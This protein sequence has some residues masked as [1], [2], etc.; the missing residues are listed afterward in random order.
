MLARI[1]LLLVVIVD[2]MGQGLIFP[3]INTLLIDP[4]A[5]FLPKGTLSSTREFYYGLVS[6][7]FYLFWFFGAAYI[8]KLSD[9]IGRKTGIV[10]CLVGAVAGYGLTILAIEFSSLWMLIL[11][12]A[13]SGFT[14]GN[15]PIAQAALIDASETEQEKSS[16][17]GYIVGASAIGMMIGPL[18]AGVL[19]DN[20]ILGSYA[21]LELPFYVAIVLVVLTLALIL[22][23]YSDVRL[24]RKPIDFGLSEVF[25]TLYRIREFP[26]VQKL[27][28]GYFFFLMGLNAYYIYLADYLIERFKFTTF[29][30]SMM[31]VILGLALML[32]GTVLV[33]YVSKRYRKIPTIVATAIVMSVFIILF[34][35]NP[36]PDLSYILIIPILLAFGLGYPT[37]LALFSASVDETRQGWVMG[38]TIAWFTMGSGTIALIGGPLMSLSIYLPFSVGVASFGMCLLFVFTIW[39]NKEV[40]ALDPAIQARD[41]TSD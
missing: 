9:H 4:T 25:L 29:Q 8:S 32:G 28:F 10:I 34:M 14:A 23:A 12:R 16:N 26:V 3:I 39:Q 6:A 15:Q 38:V 2:L 41:K 19:S 24:E 17:L 1:A 20:N 30:N 35:I 40:Q 36:V 13:I 7:V 33:P 5:T 31:L 21:S 22:G 27:S 37:L 18:L 11:G